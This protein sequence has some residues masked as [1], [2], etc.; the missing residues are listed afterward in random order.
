MFDHIH[1]CQCTTLIIDIFY[2]ILLKIIYFESTHRDKS[3]I[4]SYDNI[5]MYEKY[6]QNSSY[7]NS[8]KVKIKLF[9]LERR[10]SFIL[11]WGKYIK[12][13]T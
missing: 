11:A 12:R 2:H 5:Y 10:V 13:V 6:S 1:V 3:N 7:I 4:I 8:T 9:I